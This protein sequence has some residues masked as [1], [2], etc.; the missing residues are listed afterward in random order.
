MISYICIVPIPVIIDLQILHAHV[1]SL[2]IPNITCPPQR[3]ANNSHQTVARSSLL[4]ILKKSPQ[5]VQFSPHS[6]YFRPFDGNVRGAS[7][8]PTSTC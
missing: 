8:A 7:V 3:F 2:S 6:I 1:R 5:K 4:Y